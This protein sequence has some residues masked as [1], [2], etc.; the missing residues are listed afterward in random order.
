MGK[1][2]ISTNASLDGIVQD[3]DGKEGFQQGGWFAEFGGQ[4]LAEW[5]TIMLQEARGATALLLGRRS[6]EWFASRWASRADE[7]ADTL[8]AMPKYVASTSP[9]EAIWGNAT[10]L[11]GDIAGEVSKLKREL[12]GDIVVY[13]SYEL[14]RTLMEHDLVDELRLFVYPV[15][16][17]A[18]QRLFG[19]ISDKKP[20]RLV[21][22][23]AIGNG[24]VFLTYERAR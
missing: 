10:V 5:G 24:L 12:D 8:N 3:P 1:I 13:A 20:L 23:Q 19:E 7:W 14:G 22:A 4:D 9:D 2:V 16:L 15:L 18:G 21:R 11:N 17:G 6:D